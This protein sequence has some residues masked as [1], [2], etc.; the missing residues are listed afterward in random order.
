MKI[1]FKDGHTEPAEY[2]TDHP[3]SSY[4]QQVLVSKEDGIAYGYADIIL[5]GI[6]I[7]EE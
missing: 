6:E 1:K 3:Q 5:N 2:T 7:I 4:G